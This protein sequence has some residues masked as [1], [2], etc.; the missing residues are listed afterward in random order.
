MTP[1]YL[2]NAA[3]SFPKPPEVAEAVYDFMKNIGTNIN[4]GGYRNAYRAE[5]TVFET[6]ERLCALFRGPDPRNLIFSSGVTAS[7]NLVLKGFLREGDHV[8]VSSLEHNAVMRP[9]MQLRSQGISF[10]RIP[11]NS[12]GQMKLSLLE[13]L[14]RDNTRA[15][16]CTH[17]SNVSGLIHPAA[18]LGNFC[19]RHKLLFVLDCAQT[20]GSV[21]I[22]MEKMQIDALCFTGH[23]SLLGPQGIG[24]VL[25][26]DGLGEELSPLISGGTG[27][28]SDS[29]EMPDF[30]PDRLEAGTMNL[31]GIYGLSAAL[32]FLERTG[33]ENIAGREAALTERLLKRLREIPALRILGRP[34]APSSSPEGEDSAR[35]AVEAAPQTPAYCPVLSLQAPGLPLS[36]LAFRLDERFRISSRVG[37][38]CAPSAHRAFGS[39]PEGSLRL[40]IGY[41]NTEEEIDRT[42]DALQELILELSRNSSV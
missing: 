15:L 19:R 21:P 4:R 31:P 16:V 9:L 37:L 22:D 24:G 35:D 41:F 10:T 42:A 38:H 34:D 26:R 12:I 8:L 36:E 3:T 32:S 6:R 13:G 25:L 1:I 33:I 28:R 17:A 11:T 20:A 27:S 40:S 39:F 18:L 2:D 23:K 7:L 29:E 14:L 5:N 30:L